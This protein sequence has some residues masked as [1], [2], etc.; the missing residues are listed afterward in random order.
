MLDTS[1]DSEDMRQ[2]LRTLADETGFIELPDFVNLALYH[3]TLGY[4]RRDRQRVGRN[5]QAD[6]YTA[7]SFREAFAPALMEAALGLLE[8]AELDPTQTD[9]IEIGAEPQAALLASADSPF[10]SCQARHAGEDLTLLGQ[11]VVFSNE[12]FDAQAFRQLRFDGTRW[13]EYGIRFEDETLSWTPR[14]TVSQE[15]SPYV[16]QL[17]P[18]PPAGYTL[19]LPTGSRQLA[20]RLLGQKWHG[21]FI[22]FDYGKTWRSL[23]EETPQGTARGYHSHHQDNDIL[24]QPGQRDL[25]I[26]ICWDHIEEALRQHGFDNLSLQSQEAFIVRRAP[27]L[28]QA[29]FDPSRPELDSLRG[30]L[31][32]LI[33]PAL[34]GQKFQAL[35]A[36]RPH[37]P[38]TQNP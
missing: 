28:M 18:D 33:H 17:R 26:H 21:A 31:K 25:T 16:R 5:P 24:L 29:A 8:Q 10:R 4:Y 19:D 38:K 3:P 15:A 23:A 36:I 14:P 1:I 2:A 6:F 37:C 35:S 27:K 13:L 20:H 7:S 9:W 11:L 22:A 12:L 30:K 34:M 32:E